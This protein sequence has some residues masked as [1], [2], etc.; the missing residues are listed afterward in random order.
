MRKR[1]SYRPKGIRLDAVSWVLSG[2]KPIRETGD[3]AVTL[4]IKNHLAMEEL[5]T[6]KAIRDDIDI[7]IAALNVTEALARLRIGD[8]YSSEIKAGQDALYSMARRSIESGRFILTGPELSA[9]NLA[10]EL[11]DAQLDLCTVGQ[12]ERALDIVKDEIKHKRARPIVN[13]LMDCAA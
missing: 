4:K 10:M 3:A 7:I 5:R 11:H 6:G 9:I 8:Q 13:K 2:L 1:S 12:L